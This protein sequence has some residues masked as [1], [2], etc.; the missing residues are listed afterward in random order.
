MLL[1]SC[2]YLIT[3]LMLEQAA[4]GENLMHEDFLT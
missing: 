4:L 2:Q 1:L 3:S